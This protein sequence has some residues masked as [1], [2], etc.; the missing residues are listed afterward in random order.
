MKIGKLEANNIW[1][2]NSY[3]HFILNKYINVLTLVYNQNRFREDKHFLTWHV[4]FGVLD[5]Y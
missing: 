2:L 1:L 3:K 4:A 5:P